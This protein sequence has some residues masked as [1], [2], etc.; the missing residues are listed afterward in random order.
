MPRRCAALSTWSQHNANFDKPM[1]NGMS[2]AFFQIGF[3]SR[4]KRYRDNFDVVQ[5]MLDPW[6]VIENIPGN[7]DYIF[8]TFKRPIEI[9]IQ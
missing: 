9:A 7:S 2:F 1:G 5:Q 3:G 4:R 8:T 6:E